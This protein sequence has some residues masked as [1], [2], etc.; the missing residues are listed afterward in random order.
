MKVQIDKSV[1]ER[2]ASLLKSAHV[3]INLVWE[4]HACVEEMSTALAAQEPAPAKPLSEEQCLSLWVSTYEQQEG[5]SLFGW[6]ALGLRA[7]EAA[8]GI[9]ETL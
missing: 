4:R 2:A 9:K 5:C 8:H 1:I 7:G 3:S 6:F